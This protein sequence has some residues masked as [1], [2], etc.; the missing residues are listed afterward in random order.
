MQNGI[1]KKPDPFRPADAEAREIA[2]ELMT[3]ATHAALATLRP[4]RGLP[5][6]TRIAFALDLNGVPMSLISSLSLHTQAL[7]HSPDC[8][9]LVGEPSEKGDPLVHPRLTLHCRAQFID[10]ASDDHAMLRAH[11]LKQRPKAALYVDFG[12]FCFVRFE[13]EDAVLNGGFGRAYLLTPDDLI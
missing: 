3:Q 2:A 13:I 10:R 7:E 4:E 8:A 1:M 6:V 11:Y 9:L 12:D 5:S